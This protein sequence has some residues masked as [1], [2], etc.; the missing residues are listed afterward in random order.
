M[1]D[2][3]LLQGVASSEEQNEASFP[4][5]PASVDF[6]FLTHA[7]IDHIGRVPKLVKEGFKGAIYSTN[8]TKELSRL[9]LTD[10]LKIMQ[11]EERDKGVPPL[12]NEQDLDR[13]FNIWQTLRYH[14]AL[15]LDGNLKVL[16]RNSGHILGSAMYEFASSGDIRTI[17]TGDL[18]NSPSILL[19]DCE[20]VEDATHLVIDSVYGDRNHESLEKS[21]DRFRKA[22]VDTVKEDGTV[23]IPSFALERTQMILYLLNEL[24]ESGVIS[25]VP[26]LVDSPLAIAI[27]EIYERGNS[28]YNTNIQNDTASGDK[29][30][31]FPELK[32]AMR[33]ADSAEISRQDGAKIIIAGSGMSTAG[34]I[35][36]HEKKYLPD[37]KTTII[38]TGYQAPATPGRAIE[39]NEKKV[40]IDGEEVPVNAKVIKIDGFSGHMDSD[41]LLEFVA[42]ASEGP[43]KKVFVV[44]GEPRSSQF[45][46][47]RINDYIG[48]EAICPEIGKA[49]EL[50]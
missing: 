47:Q 1:I 35:L 4:Y 24:V 30:F 32:K 23:L 43:L 29:I 31:Q 12:Y 7:H 8:E 5:D 40:V 19:P 42:K 38:L 37:P 21:M 36:S 50:V 11:Y 17:F 45:L 41:H 46:T 20:F 27:T 39:N 2:C 33:V 18:G 3:G 22:V 34:R 9:M 25:E 14:D 15:S 26:V 44:M 13:T 48:V 6:L 49:Y 28:Q 10:A 16:A